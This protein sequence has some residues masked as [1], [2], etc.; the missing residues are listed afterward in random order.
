VADLGRASLGLGYVVTTL[1]RKGRDDAVAP[2]HKALVLIVLVAAVVL[3]DAF[4]Q[5]LGQRGLAVLGRRSTTRARTSRH[6]DCS[7]T[8]VARS[9]APCRRLGC[10]SQRCSS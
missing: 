3:P 6:N 9:A 2:A 1:K 8:G 4:A 7:S 5:C 10:L